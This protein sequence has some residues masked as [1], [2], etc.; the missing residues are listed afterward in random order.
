[1][2]VEEEERVWQIKAGGASQTRFEPQ[3]HDQEDH[4]GHSQDG[5]DGDQDDDEADVQVLGGL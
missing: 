4:N 3:K 2:I 5:D 1:M